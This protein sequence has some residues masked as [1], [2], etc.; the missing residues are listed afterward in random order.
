MIRCARLAALSLALLV[1]AC[2]QQPPDCPQ[3]PPSAT[4]KSAPFGQTWV[5]TRFN[6]E[7]ILQ[8]DPEVAHPFF[9]VPGSYVIEGWDVW[10]W[11]ASSKRTAYWASEAEFEKDVRAQGGSLPGVQAVLYDPE[12]WA[13]TP[14]EEQ[15]DPASAMRRFSKLA[16]KLGYNVIITPGLTLPS[17][18]GAACKREENETAY[19]AYSRCDIAGSAAKSADVVEVQAQTLQGNPEAYRAFVSA[20]AKQARTADPDVKVISGLRVRSE[21]SLDD[22]KRTWLAVLDV[23]DGHYLAMSPADAAVLLR[24]ISGCAAR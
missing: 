2:R 15:R 14:I 24:W 18:D 11:A 20:A 7:G 1:V 9:D 16:H 22:V 3:N 4:A 12:A 23:V 21:E 5:G 6:V 19:D 8:I 17:V 13:A 10:P